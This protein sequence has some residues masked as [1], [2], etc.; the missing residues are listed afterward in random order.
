MRTAVRILLTLLAALLILIG[1]A[2]AVLHFVPST[3]Q[4]LIALTAFAQPLVVAPLLGV[5]VCVF[6]RRW[7][8]IFVGVLTTACCV[9]IQLPMILGAPAADRGVVLTV[10]QANI[11]RGRAD[12]SALAKLVEDNHVDVLTVSE[13]TD[14]AETQIGDSA[15]RGTLSYS[16][17]QPAKDADGTGVYSRFPVESTVAMQGYTL[18]NL[19]AVT[20]VPGGGPVQLYGL[21]LVPPYPHAKDWNAE[22]ARA[23]DTLAQV[24]AGRATIAMGDFNSTWD[25]KQFRRFL[26][27]GEPGQGGAAGYTD[28]AEAIGG[29][30]LPTYPT[31]RWFPPV[32]ALDHVLVRSA[33]VASLRSYSMP[34]SDHRA[35][36]ARVSLG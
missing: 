4:Y 28:A 32:L 3:S 19:S 26:S 23:R 30:W 25:N 34:G 11:D 31:D 15:I 21:H 1:V 22:I 14:S 12:I 17:T 27:A 33:N 24:P 6:L 13:L 35:L 9:L 36:I 10:M 29:R 8:G 2:T 16:F 18:A 5:I 7:F 20:I